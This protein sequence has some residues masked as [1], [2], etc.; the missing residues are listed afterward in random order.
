MTVLQIAGAAAVLVGIALLS[1]IAV[2]LIVGGVG[3]I[4]VAERQ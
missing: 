2:A 3:A 1:S 4:L